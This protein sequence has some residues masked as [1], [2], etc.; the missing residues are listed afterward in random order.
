MKPLHQ[1]TFTKLNHRA[2][3]Y[4][5]L[6]LE[7]LTMQ[8]RYRVLFA[9]IRQMNAKWVVLSSVLTWH[10]ES[11]THILRRCGLHTTRRRLT[12]AYTKYFRFTRIVTWLGWPLIP[13]LTLLLLWPWKEGTCRAEG[14]GCMSRGTLEMGGLYL[15]LIWT[16]SLVLSQMGG[17]EWFLKWTCLFYSKLSG[18]YLQMLNRF[19]LSY[20]PKHQITLGAGISLPLT[21]WFAIF[22]TFM[23]KFRN[24]CVYL[25]LILARRFTHVERFIIILWRYQSNVAWT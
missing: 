10:L 5:G 19:Y 16:A 8:S 23:A 11:I 4:V 14:P 7:M 12:M 17:S 13:G 21:W 18:V 25:Q 2:N 9:G 6:H 1:D 24:D 3:A 20:S 15:V 22:E